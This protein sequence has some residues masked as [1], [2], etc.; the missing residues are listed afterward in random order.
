M[1][2]LAQGQA[3]NAANPAL[4]FFGVDVHG[5][6]VDVASLSFQIWATVD[7]GERLN[8]VQIF[9]STPNAQQAVD[10]TEN[11]PDRLGLGRYVATFTVDGAEPTG[12]HEIRWF[13]AVNVGDAVQM[14]RKQFEVCTGVGPLFGTALC[15]LSD[16]RDEGIPA[17]GPG[18]IS[19]ARMLATIALASN[20]VETFTGRKFGARYETHRLSGNGVRLLTLD[21]VIIATESVDIDTTPYSQADLIVDPSLFRVF[22]RHLSGMVMPDD[23][24]SPRIEFVHSDDLL[25]VGIYRTISVNLRTLIWPDGVHNVTIVGVWGY[26]D[27]DGSPWGEIPALIRYVT[28]LIVLREMVLFSDVD[29]REDWRLRWRVTEER[30]RDQSLSLAQPRSWGGITGDPE[31]DVILARFRRPPLLGAV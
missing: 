5:H 4:V 12:L 25:G 10:L 13:W 29:C 26:T 6:L 19:D 11:G 8:P 21:E 31:I 18:S 1:V 23:R 28:K 22:N 15:L 17:T 2:A 27:A 30:T 3:S 9:P 20:F 7:E 16:L 24:E 14:V